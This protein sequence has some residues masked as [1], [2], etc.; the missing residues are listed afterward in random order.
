M[1]HSSIFNEQ[2]KRHGN[3]RAHGGGGERQKAQ[4]CLTINSTLDL[5]RPSMQFN[6][7]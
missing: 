6:A 7:H 4:T 3:A 1:P 5:T 2:M